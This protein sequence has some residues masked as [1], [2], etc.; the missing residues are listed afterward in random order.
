[1]SVIEV[2]D[3]KKKY[4]EVVAVSGVSF[5]VEKGEVF[6]LLG[7]NGAGKTTTVEMLEGITKIDEGEA[8]IEG[9]KVSQNNHTLQNI[10]GVSLQSNNF[11]D[12]L[13]LSEILSLFASFFNI[14][15]NPKEYLEEVT[16][17][18]KSKTKFKEISGGQKQRFT[19]ALALINNPKVLFLDEPTTGL[20]PQS[21]RHLWDIVEGLKEKGKTIILTTHFMDEAERLADRVAVMDSGKILKMGTPTELIQDLIKTG[22]KKKIVADERA[23]LEDVFID[24]TG[25][26]LRD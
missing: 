25:K 5:S 17:V 1:M 9:I 7:P 18:E 26:N 23:N 12:D 16:L 8:F 10:I 6:G 15:I 14:K 22:F 13:S 2:K 20:D 19:V 21:R 3:I 11:F 4:G 24:L